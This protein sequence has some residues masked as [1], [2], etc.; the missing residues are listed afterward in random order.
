MQ[1]NTNALRRIHESIRANECHSTI[2]KIIELNAKN[3]SEPTE[4]LFRLLDDYILQHSKEIIYYQK[5]ARFF[6]VAQKEPR[7]ELCLAIKIYNWL[8]PTKGSS[9][10]KGSSHLH[11][12]SHHPHRHSG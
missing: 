4:I 5:L 7:Y 8:T 9:H 10:S 1:R 11:H 2:K 3:I 12:F 6:T